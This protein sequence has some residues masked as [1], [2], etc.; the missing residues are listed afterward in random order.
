MR[1][2]AILYTICITLLVIVWQLS[3]VI[4]LLSRLAEGFGA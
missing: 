1:R 2:D 4:G 3:E